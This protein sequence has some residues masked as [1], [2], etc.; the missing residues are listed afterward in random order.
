[1]L[2]LLPIGFNADPCVNTNQQSH[3][4][5]TDKTHQV[6]LLRIWNSLY[7]HCFLSQHSSQGAKISGCGGIT[8]SIET[9]VRAAAVVDVDDDSVYGF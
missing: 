5:N 3:K 6:S 8:A 1:M 4:G 2:P 9:L 7:L